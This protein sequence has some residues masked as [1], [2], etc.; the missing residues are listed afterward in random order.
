MSLN[1]LKDEL[2]QALRQAVEAVAGDQASAVAA[3]RL[4]FGPT[5]QPEHGD[6][7]SSAAMALS[8]PLGKPPVEI[9]EALA[10]QLRQSPY[11]ASAEV[12]RPGFVNVRLSSRALEYVLRSIQSDGNS[13][14]DSTLG[15]GRTVLIEFVSANPTGPMHIGHCRHAATGDALTRILRA[16][17]YKVTTEFYINDA[18]NQIAALG[19]SFRFRCLRAAGIVDD[20]EVR[21]EQDLENAGR[22]LTFFEGERV[23]YTGEYLDEFAADF[24][25]HKSPEELRAMTKAEYAWEARNRNLEQIQ[26]D[27]A[28]LGVFFDSYV[29]ERALHDEGAVER[30]LERIKNSGVAYEKEGALWLRTQDYGDNED[31]VMVKSDGSFT[32]LVPDVAY[33]HNKFERGYDLYINVFGADHAGYPPRLRAGIAAV[34]HDPSK[35]QVIL[36]RLVFLKKMG[37]RVK[38]SKRAG[39]FV[40]LAD[41]VED[42]GPD[43]TRWFM[44]CRSTDSEFEFDMDLALQEDNQNPVFKVQYAHARICSLERKGQERGLVALNDPAR[45]AAFLTAPIEK[46]MLVFLA[47][48]PEIVERSARELAVHHVPAYALAVA[49]L[50]NR[51]WAMA[52]T[53]PSFRILENEPNLAG[54][55]LMLASSIRQVLANALGLLG[56]TAPTRMVREEEE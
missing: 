15:Q 38:F 23:Q 17:N 6:M 43:A 34:G 4:V 39:N 31:R 33:H 14:G 21:E 11:I 30:T 50:W 41:V 25:K 51:Y 48:F 40:A 42:A 20:S 2:N 36:L 24:V 1:T 8:K 54:A 55:R 52:K 35:L 22:T 7:A 49:D 53:D 12:A 27:L 26:A 56:I 5:K 9:A 46:D 37:E 44:L 18:G 47:Q 45:A 29:S 32:Y 3:D 13:F 16:A 28:A 19:H 10:A